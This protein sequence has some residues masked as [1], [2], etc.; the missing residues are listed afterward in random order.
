MSAFPTLAKMTTRTPSRVYP[1]YRPDIDGLRAV[2]VL[3][4][5]VFHAFPVW[6]KGGYIGVDVFFVISGFLISTIIFENLDRGTFSFAEFYARRIKRIFPALLLVLI[7]SFAFGWFALLS[8]EYRQLGKHIAAGAGFVSNLVLW[9]EEG[10]FDNSAETKPLQ[11]LWSL[12]IEEQFYIIWPLVVWFIRRQKFNI[13]AF[14]STV[15]F[16]SFGLNLSGINQDSVATFYSPQTRFWELLSGSVLAW[17]KVYNKSFLYTL[18]FHSLFAKSIDR[19]SV[20][21]NARA[22]S[23]LISLVGG[24]LLVYG[25]WWITSEVNFPGKWATIPVVGAI[26]IIFAGPKAW[27]NRKILSNRLAVWFGLISY[28]LYLW[29]WPLLSF[30]RIVEG[31][32][33]SYNIR[34]AAIVFSIILA[35]L[36]YRVV[37][38]PIRSARVGANVAALVVFM[39]FVFFVG[40]NTYIKD[41]Y[42]FRSS[43][44]LFVNNKNELIRTSASDEAC[45]LYVGLKAPLFPYCRFTNVNSDET[46]AVIGDSHAHVSYPGISELLSSRGKNTVL[47][48]NSGCPPFLGSPTGDNKAELDACVDR[49]EQ[50]LEILESKKD[51]RKIFV[52]TRGPIY[53]T[54]TEPLTG[55][56]ALGVTNIPLQKFLNSAQ[57]S[58]NRIASKGKAVFY[59][60]ENPELNFH[61]N[62][63][64]ARP[65][66]VSP[67]NCVVQRR[68]V[69]A[70]QADYINGFS[71]IKNITF[72]DSLPVF[73]PTDRCRIFDEEGALLYAD[74]DHLS[75]AGSRFQAKK[76][77]SAYL[78]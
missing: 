41:G 15:F 11:H 18:K 43:I 49:M 32:V 5:V 75:V 24:A 45:L 33:P 62:S 29:H 4:V 60:S 74:D 28:P 63:C 39:T 59:V 36:T 9:G 77:L 73:C 40:Y 67:K 31:E 61:P 25:F 12:G 58:F 78:N 22:L 37:E 65:F 48:A 46:V 20:G 47:L 6:M 42:A 34:I 52:F 19:W 57:I 66:N 27:V 17:F 38:R 13:L 54:N 21:A 1:K 2:A 10:Y 30:A 14:T 44:K 7:A 72:I 76:L 56:K 3:S 53:I 35:W 16:I 26:L 64:F 51:I 71:K 23:N 55:D 50:L 70:R 68:S 69:Y 8:D